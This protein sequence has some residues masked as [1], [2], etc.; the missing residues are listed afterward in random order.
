ML[1]LLAQLVVLLLQQ[2]LPQFTIFLLAQLGLCPF[3]L[4]L[5]PGL[6]DTL[7]R[8]GSE[9]PRQTTPGGE[10]D[11]PLGRIELPP[12]NAVAVVI[13]EQVVKVVV[14]LAKGEKSQDAV[15]AS[16]IAI[17]IGL[18]AP[19]VGQRVD[20]EGGVVSHHHPQHAR[21]QQHAE[22]I[23]VPQAKQQR[24]PQ[25][26]RQ[27]QRQIVTVLK[28]DHRVVLQ[29]SH[30]AVITIAIS[31][32]L[33]QHPADV[34]IPE[35]APRAVGVFIVVIHMTMV[36]AVIGRPVQGRILQRQRTADGK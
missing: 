28:R 22:H 23:P 9:I 17:G 31:L 34:G 33:P 18:T 1:Q 35:T 2:R 21:Q 26:S 4:H 10:P 20:E 11:Q 5:Q 19:D 27:R 14:P 29:V 36:T 12:V 24:Q 8:R 7:L 6:F 15:I 3:Q 30:I 25:I 13:L 32:M 16:G